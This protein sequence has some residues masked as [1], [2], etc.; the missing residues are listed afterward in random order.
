MNSVVDNPRDYWRSASQAENYE[1]GRF[2][3]LKG[4]VYRLLEERT[5]CRAIQPL[6]RRSRILDAACGTGR[7]ASLLVREGFTPIGCDISIPM[8]AVARRRLG[9]VSF[10]QSDVTWLPFC[11]DSF[12]AVTCIGLLPHLNGDMRVNVLRELARVSRCLLVAQYGWVGAFLRAKRWVTGQEPGAVRYAVV[13]A[14][15][16][17][18]LQRSELMEVA[19][20]W[21]QRPLSSSLIMV[22]AK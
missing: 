8:I 6:E 13:E 19:R 22:L 17:R 10:L 20:Y 18:D 11:D 16:R 5:I 3:S 4:R 12:D 1:R 21:V 15:L 2:A 9:Q 14:E 7:I